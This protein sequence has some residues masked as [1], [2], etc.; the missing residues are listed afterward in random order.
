MNMSGSPETEGR[1]FCGA[2]CDLSSRKGM[3][4]RVD[5]V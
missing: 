1:F 5:A 4:K 3:A 2:F